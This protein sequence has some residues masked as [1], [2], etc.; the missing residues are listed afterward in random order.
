MQAVFEDLKKTVLAGK[1][2]F[3]RLFSRLKKS[4]YEKKVSKKGRQFLNLLKWL[5]CSAQGKGGFYD[6]CRLQQG[7]R[8][9]HIG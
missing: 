1:C 3:L 8:Q 9:D 7:E 5:W 4:F 6:Q 2:R